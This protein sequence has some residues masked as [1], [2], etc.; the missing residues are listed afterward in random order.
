MKY[1][2][3]CCLDG[4]AWINGS[5][6]CS[7]TVHI[8]LTCSCWLCVCFK[9]PQESLSAQSPCFHLHACTRVYPV[10]HT[11]THILTHLIDTELTENLS[12]LFSCYCTTFISLWTFCMPVKMFPLLQSGM[13][14]VHQPLSA[15]CVVIIGWTT[16]VTV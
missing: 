2:K 12:T 16:G 8:L 6:A 5:F 13:L 14:Y 4:F 1:L 15:A 9:R 10:I 11:R 7:C 3:T